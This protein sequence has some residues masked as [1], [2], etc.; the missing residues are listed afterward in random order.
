[1]KLSF[2]ISNVFAES[3]WGGNPLAIVPL[4][5]GQSLD[6]AT[7]QRIARQFNLSETVFITPPTAS[8]H[9][10]HLRIFTPSYELPFAGHPTIGSAQWL[11]QHLNL[12]DTFTLTT[13]AKTATITQREGVY[14]FAL[15]GYE[16]APCAF[17]TEHLTQH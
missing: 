7:M 16:S 3:A 6:T 4:L 13:P 8:H 10:A 14:R 1:M 5:N 15:S 11:H 17:T 9:A 2:Y 12:P